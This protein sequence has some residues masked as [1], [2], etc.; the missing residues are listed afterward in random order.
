MVQTLKEKLEL[1]DTYLKSILDFVLLKRAR[2]SYGGRQILDYATRCFCIRPHSTLTTLRNK[3]HFLYHKG[4]EKLKR[5]LDI[6]NLVRSIR[7][8]RLMA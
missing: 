1:D 3:D 4:N 7:Q 5:E 6:V 2:F 8:L